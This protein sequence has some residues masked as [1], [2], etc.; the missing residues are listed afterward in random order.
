MSIRTESESGTFG[1][2]I[3]AMLVSL[4][5]DTEDPLE[6]LRAVAA[7]SAAAKAQEEVLSGSL[8]AELGQLTVPV[9]ASVA[10]RFISEVHLFDRVPPPF[11][12]TMS[13]IAGPTFD[14][15]WAGRRLAALY[16]IG[17]ITDGV[18]LNIT[19]MSYLDSLYLGLLGCRRLIPDIAD[20]GDRIVESLD[21]LVKIAEDHPS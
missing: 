13:N 10:A 5:T 21:Q 15:F 14:L 6:R 16:P 2:R 1:N 18:A 7:S 17:P 12:L 3:S 9:V 20:L 4:A 8:L 19:A 11:N